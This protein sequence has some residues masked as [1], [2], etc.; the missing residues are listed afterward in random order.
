MEIYLVGG[1][2]RDRLLNHPVTERDWVVVGSTEKQLLELGYTPVGKDFPV[3]LHPKSKE[4]YALARLERKTGQGHKGFECDASEFVTLEDDL[5]RRDLTINAIAESSN[6]ELVDPYG[7]R[8]D[9]ESRILRHVS[10]AFEEDPLR[11]LRL[12]RFKAK[13]TN[14][15][16]HESTFELMRHMIV[17]GDLRELPPERIY[18]ELDK[19]LATKNVSEFFQLLDQLGASEELWPMITKQ[20]VHRLATVASMTNEKDFRIAG[21]L[22]FN[23]PSDINAFSKRLRCPKRLIELSLLCSSQRGGWQNIGTAEDSIKWLYTIDAF[24][25]NERFLRFNQLLALMTEIEGGI[26]NQPYW[27]DVYERAIRVSAKDL[28]AKYQGA[29]LGLAIKQAQI[30]AIS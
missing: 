11:I 26:D 8:Q 6:G 19:A 4:E 12:A 5:L 9:L 24:R 10:T 3:F 21:L 2:I 20:G 18:A 16:V 14:F 23:S 13:L 29:E 27:L 7:G 15:T 17:R 30:E 28:A 22:N 1:A 25:R